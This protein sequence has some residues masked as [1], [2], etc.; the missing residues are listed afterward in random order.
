MLLYAS[1]TLPGVTGAQGT[2]PAVTVPGHPSTAEMIARYADRSG[3]DVRD[4]RW[5]E[6]F[7][8]YKLAAIAQGVYHRYRQGA[9]G[10]QSGFAD[11]GDIVAPLIADGIGILRER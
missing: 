6:A 1:R 8:R 5:Y 4:L 9:Y 11:M 7:A 3:R 10:R 2:G